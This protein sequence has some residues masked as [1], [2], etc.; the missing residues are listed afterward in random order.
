MVWE[1]D[2]SMAGHA[3]MRNVAIC[4]ACTLPHMGFQQACCV[5]SYGSNFDCSP[6]QYPSKI[7]DAILCDAA[8]IS[9][10]C[11]L[12]TMCNLSSPRS[13]PVPSCRCGLYA[14]RTASQGWAR[15][16][17]GTGRSLSQLKCKE[18]NDCAR[19]WHSCSHT[20]GVFPTVLD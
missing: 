8:C 10:M 3:C 4:Q 6:I 2:R 9:A 7:V 11:T 18:L 14:D 16:F 1:E 13:L 15:R 17:L 19:A 20:T 12:L 5:I